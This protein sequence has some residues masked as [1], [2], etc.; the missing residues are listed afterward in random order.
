MSLYKVFH[1]WEHGGKFY[2]YFRKG[3]GNTLYIGPKDN[4]KL[5]RVLE[6]IV[7]IQTVISGKEKTLKE[8]QDFLLT[9]TV[10]T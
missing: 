6:A 9:A 8:L 7:Y 4:P 5:E 1:K 3:R 2:W 10:K